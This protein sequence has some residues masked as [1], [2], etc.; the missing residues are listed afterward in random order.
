MKGLKLHLA[1]QTLC[2]FNKPR[3]P[4]YGTGVWKLK[5]GRRGTW[6]LQMYCVKSLV[7]APRIRVC[8]LGEAHAEA[9]L[10][11]RWC[12]RGEDIDFKL[13]IGP[14]AHRRLCVREKRPL[15]PSQRVGICMD[16]P[17]THHCKQVMGGGKAISAPLLTQ[18]VSAQKISHQ[19][20]LGLPSPP[21]SQSKD[22]TGMRI[23]RKVMGRSS[24]G[25][26]ETPCSL[27][28]DKHRRLVK[29][30]QPCSIHAREHG[31]VKMEPHAVSVLSALNPLK[32][33]TFLFVQTWLNISK[34]GFGPACQTCKVTLG[35]VRAP[36]NCLMFG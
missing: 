33:G 34:I 19:W 14:I 30:I 7:K 29:I 21:R 36:A 32:W 26:E 9:R 3:A 22:L 35:L 20:P 15:L 24:G 28:G 6:F 11:F 8:A 4:T 12:C 27:P 31:N 23:K 13:H 10:I 25:G 18:S 16:F 5:E 2:Y 1:W 17:P